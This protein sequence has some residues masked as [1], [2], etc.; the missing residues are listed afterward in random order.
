MEE[1]GNT[2][3]AKVAFQ[4]DREEDPRSAIELVI[5]YMRSL[6]HSTQGPNACVGAVRQCRSAVETALA[7]LKPQEWSYQ[8]DSFTQQQFNEA[9]LQAPGG[10]AMTAANHFNAMQ[11]QKV[12]QLHQVNNIADQYFYGKMTTSWNV[13]ANQG[14]IE[15]KLQALLPLL[16]NAAFKQQV[17]AQAAI[18]QQTTATQRQKKLEEG[19]AQLAAA[20][21]RQAGG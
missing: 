2:E 8:L 5:E 14:H 1:S 4:A 17:S 12:A 9:Q 11:L 13:G 16:H 6:I 3:A 18:C 20:R 10:S 21:R 7:F 19:R 15:D